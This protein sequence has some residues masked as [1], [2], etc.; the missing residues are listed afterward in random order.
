MMVYYNE[1]RLKK[2]TT[3]MYKNGGKM[4]EI[5]LKMVDNG[6][7]EDENSNV[8]WL[9]FDELLQKSTEPHMICVYKKIIERVKSFK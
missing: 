9:T 4:M 2:Y 6:I 8:G 3:L 1:L 5:K 7:Y